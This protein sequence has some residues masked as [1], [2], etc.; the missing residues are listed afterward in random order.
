MKRRKFTSEFKLQCVLDHVERFVLWLSR[1][2]EQEK[3]Q[4]RYAVNITWANRH[5]V[6]GVTSLLKERQ[7]YLTTGHLLR[8]QNHR[9]CPN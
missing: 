3:I 6:V 1:R 7:R 8:A 4:L 9:E 5:S 2:K